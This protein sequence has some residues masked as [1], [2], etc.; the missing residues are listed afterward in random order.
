VPWTSLLSCMFSYSEC[1][2]FEI[3]CIVWKASFFPLLSL[4]PGR[5]VKFSGKLSINVI[6]YAAMQGHL[7]TY[8]YFCTLTRDSAIMTQYVT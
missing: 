3:T 2:M 1:G 4:V 7:L 8:K 6:S 5:I